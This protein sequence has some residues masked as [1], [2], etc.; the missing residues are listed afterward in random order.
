MLAL[1]VLSLLIGGYWLYSG[2]T[3]Q[4]VFSVLTAIFAL[5]TFRR[6]DDA[7]VPSE[8]PRFLSTRRVPERM[9]YGRVVVWGWFAFCL[10]VASYRFPDSV[11]GGTTVL[12]SGILVVVVY[13]D[14]VASET[15]P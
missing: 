3:V 10:A 11:L 1:A 5:L 4:A 6:L 8:G 12:L 7:P 2:R 13:R 9:R 15:G 14:I